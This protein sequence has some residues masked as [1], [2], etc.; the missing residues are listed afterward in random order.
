MQFDQLNRRDFITLLGG[1]A[2]AWPVAARAQQPASRVRRIAVLLRGAQNDLDTQRDL[3]NFRKGLW[4]LGWTI[5]SNILIEYR[6]ANADPAQIQTYAA[7]LVGLPAEVILAE[8]SFAVAA[9][10]RE[11]RTTPIVF[12]RVAEPV[13]QGF[14]ASLAHPGANVTGFSSLEYELSGKWLELLK[15]LAPHLVR[16]SLMFNPATDPYGPGFLRSLE[17]AAPSFGV[18]PIGALIHDPAEIEGTMSVLGSGADGGLIV[19]PGAFTD[20]HREQVIALAAHH[21]VPAIYTYRY[22]TAAGGLISYGVNSADMY[23]RAPAYVDRILKGEKPADLP[24]Q[25]PTAFDLA[26]NLKTAKALGLTVPANLL[27]LVDEVIE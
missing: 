7:E 15:G 17:T 5:G 12:V 25:R 24:V 14:V 22:F 6:Y 4:E 16:V 19:L 3:Q 27:A 10:R 8:G 13:S 11:T 21:R 23:R 9:L 2:G 18:K 20:V 1:A 26:I